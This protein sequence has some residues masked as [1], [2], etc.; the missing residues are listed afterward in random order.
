M[1]AAAPTRCPPARWSTCSRCRALG[2]IEAT[3]INAGNAHHF[4]LRAADIGLKGTELQPE[5][6]NNPE[7]LAKLD[8]IRAVGAVAMGLAKTPAEAT[9]KRPGTP[10]IS[11]CR[12]AGGLYFIERRTM[13]EANGTSTALRA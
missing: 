6:N 9:A 4:R 1:P 12:A 11:F 3:L 13:V 2:K 7:T 5:I 10:K 8:A